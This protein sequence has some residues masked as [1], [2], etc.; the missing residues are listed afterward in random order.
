[1]SISHAAP[2]PQEE[3]ER[4]ATSIL[5]IPADRITRADR[6]WYHTRAK[7]GE[8][9][10]AYPSPSGTQWFL[11]DTDTRIPLVPLGIAYE[12]VFLTV[13]RGQH[14]EWVIEWR[15]PG[16]ATLERCTISVA[17]WFDEPDQAYQARVRRIAR[18]KLAEA[19]QA[20]WSPNVFSGLHF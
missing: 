1:M 4:H 16:Q 8:D 5:A 15:G 13:A 12:L 20:C 2:A 14:L 17:Q 9:V 18:G 19:A 10:Y 7:A 6:A 11:W 3:R